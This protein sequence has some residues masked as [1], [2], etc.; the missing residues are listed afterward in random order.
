MGTK[1]GVGGAIRDLP[2]IGLGDKIDH[3][4]AGMLLCGGAYG[5]ALLVTK[6]TGLYLPAIP[7][8]LGCAVFGAALIELGQKHTHSGV[9]SWADFFATV[10]PVALLSGLLYFLR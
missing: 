10:A 9:A 7:F 6:I 5:L 1:S 2:G 4:I 8:A 3:A